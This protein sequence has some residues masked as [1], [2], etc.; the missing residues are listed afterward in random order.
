[1]AGTIV[2][3]LIAHW[4]D[5]FAGPNRDY[6]AVVGISEHMMIVCRKR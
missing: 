2:Q 5:V 1:M 6:P 3:A 4:D